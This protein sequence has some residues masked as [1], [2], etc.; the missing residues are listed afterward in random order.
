MHFI[1][2][3][4]VDLIVPEFIANNNGNNELEDAR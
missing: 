4:T 2:V 1:E 3:D